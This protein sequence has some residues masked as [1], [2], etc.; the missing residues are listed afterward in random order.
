[1]KIYGLESLFEF[2]LILGCFESDAITPTIRVCSDDRPQVERLLCRRISQQLK[3][4]TSAKGSR[5]DD[6]FISGLTVVIEEECQNVADRCSICDILLSSQGLSSG[7]KLTYCDNL[8][9]G[10]SFTELGVCFNV[11]EEIQRNGTAVEL[12]LSFAYAAL[13]SSGSHRER[14]FTSCPTDFLASNGTADFSKLS[15]GLSL[16]PPIQSLRKVSS[17]GEIRKTLGPENFRLLRYIIATNRSFILSVPS[18]SKYYLSGLGG[19]QFL[20]SSA[21]PKREVK[22]QQACQQYGYTWAYHGSRSCNWWNI[23][24]LNQGVK[25]LSGTTLQRNGAAHGPGVYLSITPGTACSYGGGFSPR[26]GISNISSGSAVVVCQIVKAP[27]YNSWVKSNSYLVI[28]NDF[29]VLPRY[30]VINCNSSG[31]VG[32][33][34]TTNFC[35]SEVLSELFT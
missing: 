24:G 10:F 23:I 27:E 3:T 16:I 15:S 12:L 4:I 35:S 31:N 1:M 22:F 6:L 18:T 19:D 25:N 26:P 20:I 30:F 28:P 8:A 5:I 11:I 2:V 34:N 13:S 9:C 32:N 17:D 29:Y 14:L 21:D 7:P 33:I